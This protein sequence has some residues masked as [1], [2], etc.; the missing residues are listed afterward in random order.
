MKRALEDYQANYHLLTDAEHQEQLDALNL[1]PG[2]SIS[3]QAYGL[4]AKCHYVNEETKE[5][6]HRFELTRVTSAE[7]H[8]ALQ[9]MVS[10]IPNKRQQRVYREMLRE[11]KGGN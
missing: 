8:I 3:V 7:L 11:M 9:E 6:I 5:I 1:Q 4:T 2:D 10:G